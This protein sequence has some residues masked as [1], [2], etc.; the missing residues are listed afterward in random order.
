MSEITVI[1]TFPNNSWDVYAKKMLESYVAN[2]EVDIPLLVQLDDD[3]LLQQASAAT[4]PQDA[5]SVGRTPEHQ[6]F[7]DRNKGRDD[8]QNYR[9]QAVRFCHKVFALHKAVQAIRDA[10]K[11]NVS[12][13]RYLIWMDADV[14]TTQKVTVEMLKKCFPKEGDAVS[15]LGRKDW[16]HSE[17]GWLVF[18]LDNKGD[19]IIEAMHKVYCDDTLFEME[20][21]HDSYVFDE[22]RKPYKCTN[23]TED[24]P[25]MEIW[26]HSPMAEWSVHYKGPLAKQKLFTDNKGIAPQQLQQLQPGLGKNFVIQTK[27]AIPHEEICKHIE[28]NQKLIKNWVSECGITSDIVTVVSAGPL[29]IPEDVRNEAKKGNKIVAVKHALTPLKKAGITP[30]ACI[31]LDPRPHVADFVKEADNKVLWFVA[32]QVNPEV[33][34]ALLEKG[35]EVWG[36][37]ASVGAGE[38]ELTNLQPDAVIEGGSATATRGLYLLY[39]LGFRNFNLYGYDLCYPDKPDLNAITEEGQPKFLEFSVGIKNPFVDGK[40]QFYSEPQLIAQFEELIAMIKMEKFN[41][42]AFGDGMIPYILK[43]FEVSKLRQ[44]EIKDRLGKRFASYKHMLKGR[45]GLNLMH[46]FFYNRAWNKLKKTK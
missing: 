34:K 39:H 4:R 41:L 19:E 40:K 29:M 30:W 33:T 45:G 8:Q 17:C 26:Q 23:L 7:I 5:I 32:S 10:K 18:D 1:T 28:E 42:K 24:K 12:T 16:E 35:C 21:W 14:V 22:I 13:P 25:G 38:S 46:A 37:H 11:N 6:S 31:L 27:N 44:Q 20:Q 3:L 15:F 43:L 2:W 36:Y 9:K